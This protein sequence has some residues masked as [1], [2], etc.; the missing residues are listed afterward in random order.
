MIYFHQNCFTFAV[1]KLLAAYL[2]CKAPRAKSKNGTACSLP[3][4]KLV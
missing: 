2:C 1:G 3:G 4:S